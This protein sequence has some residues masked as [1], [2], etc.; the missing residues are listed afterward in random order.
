[1]LHPTS[2]YCLNHGLLIAACWSVCAGKTT[3]AQRFGTMFKN[4]NLLPRADVEVGRLVGRLAGGLAGALIILSS[5]RPND[6]APVLLSP[7]LSAKSYLFATVLC[8]TV[9]PVRGLV[10]GAG[11]DCGEFDLTLHGQHGPQCGGRHAQVG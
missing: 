4:L 5:T 10:G 2:W 6:S 3:V 7:Y 9:C 11:G 8:C 1:M